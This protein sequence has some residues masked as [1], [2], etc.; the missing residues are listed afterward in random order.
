MALKDLPINYIITL[1]AENPDETSFPI[2]GPGYGPDVP[3][4]LLQN[5]INTRPLPSTVGNGGSVN[6]ASGVP[7]GLNPVVDASRKKKK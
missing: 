6:G 3:R 1:L 7:V 4:A 2:S 5:E